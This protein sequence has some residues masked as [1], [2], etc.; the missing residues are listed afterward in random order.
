MFLEQF[1]VVVEEGGDRVLRQDVVPD[2][3]LHEPKV[4]GNVLL[5]TTTMFNIINRENRQLSVF[6]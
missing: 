6:Y 3:L 1:P 5:K 2:L 4:L